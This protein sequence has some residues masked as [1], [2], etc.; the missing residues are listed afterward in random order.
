MKKYG[1][2]FF[3]VDKLMDNLYGM[4]ADKVALI[5]EKVTIGPQVS[6][7]KRMCSPEPFQAFS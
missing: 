5:P 4:E 2:T 7:A 6:D 1:A 3:G